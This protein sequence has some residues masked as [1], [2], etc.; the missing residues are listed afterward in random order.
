MRPE[1]SHVLANISDRLPSF[2]SQQQCFLLCHITATIS[3]FHEE[4]LVPVRPSN[5]PE[6]IRVG[7]AHEMSKTGLTSFFEPVS[8]KQEQGFE[9]AAI[10]SRVGLTSDRSGVVSPFD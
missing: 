3:R 7:P 4:Y 1:L 10:S 8:C 9:W 6:L 5:R 2:R